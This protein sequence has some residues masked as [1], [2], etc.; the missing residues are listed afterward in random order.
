M[1]DLIDN[2]VANSGLVTINLEE[3]LEVDA[4]AEFDLGAF[5]YMG[6]ILREK[7]FREALKAFDFST[8]KDKNVAVFCSVDA[9]IPVWAYMLIGSYLQPVAA[10]V[11]YG[12]KEVAQTSF[13]VEK[14]HC[15]PIDAFVDQRV[16]VKGCGEITIHESVYLAITVR[17]LSVC[18]SI[19]Y[20]EPCSTVPIFKRK[21]GSSS[22]V[23]N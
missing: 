12:N 13:L 17:L 20:G 15:L 7:D 14:M 9:I 11:F 18:K 1:S 5:L 6:L 10:I 23:A 8:F 16:V 2:K 22:L 4:W 21:A 3:Y 19:M